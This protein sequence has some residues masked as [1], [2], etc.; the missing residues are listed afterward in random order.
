MQMVCV[1]LRP[2]P[3]TQWQEEIELKLAEIPTDLV[4]GG[5]EQRWKVWAG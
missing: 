1:R 3:F 4:C 5:N 2:R